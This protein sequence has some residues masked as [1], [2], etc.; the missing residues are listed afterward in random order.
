MSLKSTSFFNPIRPQI[1]FVDSF[2]TLIK[3]NIFI[4]SSFFKEFYL[5]TL[6]STLFESTGFCGSSL[7]RRVP[8]N[9]RSLKLNLLTTNCLCVHLIY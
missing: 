5:T 3:E 6:S 8:E 4:R 7:F 2:V 9:R 1:H